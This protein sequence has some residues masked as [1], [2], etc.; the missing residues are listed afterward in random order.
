[1]SVYPHV[2]ESYPIWS[3]IDGI[4]CGWIYIYIS[5]LINAAVEYI[6]TYV[7]FFMLLLIV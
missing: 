6:S 4:G 3:V 2:S 1:M 7:S 5:A